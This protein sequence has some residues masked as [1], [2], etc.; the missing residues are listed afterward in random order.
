M[1]TAD[2]SNEIYLPTEIVMQ[3]MSYVSNTSD[4]PDR[5]QATLYAC[6]LV[7]T[8]WYSAAT[9]H[10]Y[11]RPIL[12]FGSSFT[13][14][15]ATISPP[16][17]VARKNKLKLGSYVRRLDLSGLVHHSSPSLTARLLGKVK[18]NLV[19]FSAPRVS[20][21]INCLPALSKCT[22][23][24]SLDLSLVAEP[25]PFLEFKRSLSNLSKLTTLRLPRTNN[26]IPPPPS[27]LLSSSASPSTIPWPPRLQN[28]QVTGDFSTNP[29]LARYFAWPP[30]LTSLILKNCKNLDSSPLTTILLENPSL[31]TT[32]KRL[33]IDPSNHLSLTF[34]NQLPL[35]MPNL[36]YLSVPGDTIDLTFFENLDERM[37]LL[38]QPLAL[39]TLEIDQPCSDTAASLMYFTPPTLVHALQNGLANV[40]SVGISEAWELKGGE[41]EEIDS[42]LRSRFS[43]KKQ[44]KQQQQ[45]PV[46][47][48]GAA[49][50]PSPPASVD[51]E[52]EDDVDDD[53][54]VYY[55]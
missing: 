6:C 3:I 42:V 28:L 50:M 16:L 29:L 48:A 37:Q 2:A 44:G 10:L 30:A 51:D 12:R 26:L 49:G 54:G 13:Q 7:S 35:T 21:A 17:H 36:D 34:V 19:V 27:T 25:F 14:F 11:E 5:R 40:R 23:L 53:V 46:D 1:M 38:R 8:Q 39:R 24:Q 45:P 33:K 9:P 20:F 43:K 52:D 32:L 22:K 31:H 15:A 41:V 47:Q 4:K 55:L 18:E